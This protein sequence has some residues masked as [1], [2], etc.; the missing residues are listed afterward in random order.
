MTLQNVSPLPLGILPHPWVLGTV[1][2]IDAAGEKV[3]WVFEV[4]ETGNIDRVTFRT[5]AVSDSQTL[6]IGIY[7]LDSNGD[8]TATLYGGSAVA[9]Q[10]S[11][12]ASTTYEVILGT[13]AAATKNDEV[14]VVIE[15]NST[16]GNVTFTGSAIVTA[17]VFPYSGAFTTGWTKNTTNIPF[18]GVRYDTGAYHNVGCVP[19]SIGVLASFNS[20]SNPDELGNIITMPFKARTSGFWALAEFDITCDVVLYDS[21]GVLSTRTL[22]VNNRGSTGTGLSWR[23]WSAG[24]ILS[25]GSTYRITV[26]PTASSGGMT[27]SRLTVLAAGAMAGWPLG[28]AMYETS[29]V[30]AG[31]WTDTPTQRISIGLMIDQLDDGIV[32]GSEHAYVGIG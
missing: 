17:A 5:S 6:K 25:Y 29:R 26:K 20:G 3:S 30:N 13:P 21:N 11:P 24:Y 31:A 18:L 12:A 1:G 32:V 16:V 27:V 23:R 10:A 14:A 19:G 7:T 22:A 28:T 9:T 2:G 4:P 8:P 15:F